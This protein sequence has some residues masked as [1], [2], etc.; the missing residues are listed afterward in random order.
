MIGTALRGAQAAADL[1]PVELRQHHVEHDE[2]ERLLGEAVER[3]AAVDG[4]HDLVAVLAQRIGQQRL[5]RLLVVDEQDA[6]GRSAIADSVS[7]RMLDP[8]IYRAALIPALLA[9]I[10]VAFSLED[11]PRPVGTTLA[12]IAFDGDRAWQELQGRDGLA[13]RY[14][15]R[16]PGSPD[17]EALA[18]HVSDSLRRLGFDVRSETRSQV[19][20]DGKRDLRTVIAERTDR[21][22]GGSSSSRRA[23]PPRPA[24]SRPCR[25]TEGLLELARVF[26]APRRTQRTLTIVSTSGSAGTTSTRDIASVLGGQP[27]EAAIVLGDLASRSTRRPFVAGWSDDLGMAP[28]RLQ[29][30]VQESLRAELGGDPRR[31][32]RARPVDALRRARL[33][34]RA[35]P[36]NDDG[37]PAV[38]I[39]ATGERGPRP[40]RASR[41]RACRP[42]AAASCAR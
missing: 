6:W 14:P 16:R 32:A 38:L 22:T 40:A 37:I 21:W 35:G 3:L 30:T 13:A 29:R 2:V 20:P 28:L 27:V 1:E 34:D 23:T 9:F 36:L 7:T 25:A 15:D 11:R 4:L 41:R 39:S 31:P 10:L 12:P 5:D 19:T 33:P 17:D 42:S 24:R 8:R 18:T 26:G